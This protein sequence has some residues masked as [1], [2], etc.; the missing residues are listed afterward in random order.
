MHARKAFLVIVF[1][2]ARHGDRDE[3]VGRGAVQNVLDEN[4]KEEFRITRS[5][6]RLGVELDG[7][8]GFVDTIDAFV[9]VVVSVVEKL[10][11][12]LRK[13]RSVDLES[14]ILTSDIAPPT[15]SVSA[16]DIVTAVAILHL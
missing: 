1:P 13:R 6:C 4:V 10:L 16:G 8:E 14:V 2:S 5:R 3:S 9:T 11:P 15:E 12:A 7:K